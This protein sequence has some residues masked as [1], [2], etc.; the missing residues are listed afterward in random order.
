MAAEEM[1]V[2]SFEDTITT[3]DIVII[4]FW[5]PWCG[6]CRSFAPIFEKVSDNHTD[7]VFAKVNTEEEQELAA[8]FQIRSIPTLMIFREQV[9]LYAEAG[10]LSEP[11]LE[12]VIAKVRELDMDKVRADIAAQEQQA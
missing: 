5:A 10:M 6:P 11:Q 7:I 3:N 9:I 2:Q 12:Q 8:N 1:T 4:D